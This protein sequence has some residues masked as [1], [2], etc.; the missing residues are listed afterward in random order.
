MGFALHA[1]GL[2]N[3]SNLLAPV[4]SLV[5]VLGL[6]QISVLYIG[7]QISMLYIIACEETKLYG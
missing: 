2:W 4:V 1:F 3:P 6:I 7:V 5:Q